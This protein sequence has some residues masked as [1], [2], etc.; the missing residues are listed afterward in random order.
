MSKKKKWI[1]HISIGILIVGA[2]IFAC[3]ALQE[4]VKYGQAANDY[5]KL[6]RNYVFPTID[7]GDFEDENSED[8]K[9]PM[10]RFVD[11]DALKKIN[12]EIIAWIYVPGTK[13]DL[14]LIHI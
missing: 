1:P 9:N 3:L 8:A 11:F 7:A 13:I 4:V 14:S 12:P 5:K 2:V 10:E 6:E